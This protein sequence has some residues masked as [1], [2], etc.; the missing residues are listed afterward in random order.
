M[1]D[2]T[3][4]I[5][6]F[7]LFIFITYNSA[8]GQENST[9]TDSTFEAYHSEVWDEI[10][11]SEFSDSLQNQYA[12]EFFEYY[13]SHKGTKSAERAFSSA[14]LMWGNTGNNQYVD[15]ALATLDNNSEL[16]TLILRPLGN[17]YARNENLDYENYIGYLEKK[18]DE[19][20]QPTS[21]SQLYLILVRHYEDQDKKDKIRDYAQK[22][23]ELDAKDFFVDFALGQLHELESLQIGQPAHV[24]A[25]ETV[26]GNSFSLSDL[27]GEFILLQFWGTWCGPCKPE[28]PHLKTLYEKHSDR[29]MTI[30]GVAL[31]ENEKLVQDFTTEN[32]IEWPQILQPKRWGGEIVESYNVAG[33][34]RMYLIDPDGKIVAKDLRGEEMVNEVDRMIAEYFDE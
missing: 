21:K 14:F 30:I 31:D 1:R 6:L 29:N 28:I 20:T 25:A 4:V 26:Q 3:R 13:K 5:S 19:L 34:P 24:F 12:E 27:S 9:E 8:F 11:K 33:V 18:E 16:W 22:M 7:I 2:F 15:E 17:I 10:E 32:E 23:V